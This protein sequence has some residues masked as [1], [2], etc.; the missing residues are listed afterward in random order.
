MPL[1]RVGSE[2]HERRVS[3][4]IAG[5]LALPGGMS[6]YGGVV[7][8]KRNDHSS[9]Y[10]FDFGQS[11]Q[12]PDISDYT[13]YEDGEDRGQHEVTVNQDYEASP[14]HNVHYDYVER[15]SDFSYYDDSDYN[16]FQGFD[17][18]HG[19]FDDYY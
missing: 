14:P 8:T 1:T 15:E 4:V 13:H 11:I 18:T 6:G 17:Y 12:H 7:A 9:D 3:S 10:A 2:D 5:V 16:G 19:A